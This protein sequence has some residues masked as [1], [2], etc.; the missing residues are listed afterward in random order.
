MGGG[1][2][3]T[4][5]FREL[6]AIVDNAACRSDLGHDLNHSYVPRCQLGGEVSIHVLTSAEPLTSWRI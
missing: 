4:K 2:V 1:E 3:S 6:I 5:D